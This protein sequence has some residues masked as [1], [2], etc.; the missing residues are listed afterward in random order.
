MLIRDAIYDRRRVG[1]R[2]SRLTEWFV[3]LHHD[4]LIHVSMSR[5]HVGDEYFLTSGDKVRF[6]LEEDAIQDGKLNRPKELAVNKMGHGV[7]Y[8]MNPNPYIMFYSPLTKL[9]MNSN[10]YSNHSHSAIH[11]LSS[12][13]ET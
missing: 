5:K 6:F 10:P 4:V 1:E 9:Y 11:D 7:F 8:K 13:P 3:R 2:V 12:W